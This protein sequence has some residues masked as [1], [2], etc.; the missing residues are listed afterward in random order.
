MELFLSLVWRLVS[1]RKLDSYLSQTFVSSALQTGVSAW[2]PPPLNSRYIFV[3]AFI[4]L[5]LQCWKDYYFFLQKYSMHSKYLWHRSWR[6]N[7]THSCAH[8]QL[9]NR[10]KTN[11]Q[12]EKERDNLAAG[13]VDPRGSPSF[14]IEWHA[15]TWI[16]NFV[17]TGLYLIV[18]NNDVT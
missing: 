7:K 13:Q 8:S 4:C 5:D 2:F 3:L 16:S 14:F 9:I 12:Q 18:C 6:G 17:S 15:G 1:L 10:Y 11:E